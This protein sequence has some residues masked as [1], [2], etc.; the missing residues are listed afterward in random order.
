VVQ[1]SDL[2]RSGRPQSLL[3]EEKVPPQGADVV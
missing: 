1:I 2:R 3:L